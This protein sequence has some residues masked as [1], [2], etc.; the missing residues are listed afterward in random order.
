[1]KSLTSIFSEGLILKGWVL[2]V[3]EEESRESFR[4]NGE[5]G[6]KMSVGSL[7]VE[8]RCQ[9]EQEDCARG[10]GAKRE[11][12]WHQMWNQKK[13]L[14]KKSLEL[15]KTFCFSLIICLS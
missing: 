13:K 1:M 11:A 9:R 14:R 5:F 8:R 12:G 6:R 3:S 7:R 4:E 15:Q 2:A 10:V